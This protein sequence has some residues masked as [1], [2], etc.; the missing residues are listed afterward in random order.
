MFPQGDRGDPGLPGFK[1]DKVSTARHFYS[2]GFVYDS[3]LFK[4]IWGGGLT[5]LATL[6][7]DQRFSLVPPTTDNQSHYP[8][9]RPRPHEAVHV[10][11]SA[12]R[13]PGCSVLRS[14]FS[15]TLQRLEG[16]VLRRRWLNIMERESTL[17]ILRER[18]VQQFQYKVDKDRSKYID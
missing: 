14:L 16:G 18:I 9:R 11:N 8:H 12:L 1:G 17:F 2:P 15:I 4:Y 10:S 3:L 13:H 7:W 6:T 5:L